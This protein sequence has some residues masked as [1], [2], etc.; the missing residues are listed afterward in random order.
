MDHEWRRA[1]HCIAL[2][3]TFPFDPAQIL[4]NPWLRRL[5]RFAFAYYRRLVSAVAMFREKRMRYG[6]HDADWPKSPAS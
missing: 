1:E 4:R 5:I 6:L 3:R 2:R